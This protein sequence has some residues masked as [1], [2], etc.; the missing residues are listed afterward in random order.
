MKKHLTVAACLAA[1]IQVGAQQRAPQNESI[2]QDDMRAD[3][4]FLAGDSLRGRLTDTEENRASADFIRSRFERMGLKGAGPG[5]SFFQPYNLMT[6]TVGDPAANML[7]IAVADG[8]TRQLRLGQE[9]YPHRFSASGT[10]AGAVVFAGFGISAPHLG[11]D[12]YN[13][14]VKGKIVLALDHEPGERDPNSPFDGVVT[15]EPSAVWRKALAAQEKGAVAVLFVS[16]VHNHP[17]TASFEAAARNYWPGTPPRILNYTL[18]AWADRV[19]I[20]VAQISPAL[21]ASLV[22]GTSRSL[23]ELAKSAETAHGLPPLALPGTRI[24]LHTLVER[25]I[26]ADRNVV[27]LLE[28]SDPRLKN[29]WVIVSAHYDHNGADATQIF[30]GADDNGS[31]VV[32]LIEIAEAYALAAKEGHRPK[33]SILFASW[34]SEE[35]GLLGAWAYTEQPLAPLNTIAAVLNMDMIGRNEEIP[36]GG[37]ARFAGLEAQTAESNSNA[38]NLMA[39]SRVPDITTMVEKANNGIGLELKKRYDNNSSNL[40]R[41]SDQWPFLQRGVAAMGFITGLHPDYHTQYDR[42]EKINYVKMEKIARLVHQVSWDI[43]NAET[44][45]KAPASR[46]ITQH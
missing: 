2:R 23:E 39:F 6:S 12:D 22:S 7:E 9:F 20:P 45:P 1:V 14:D 43:A 37:G 42:P 40:L 31:G 5:G 4:F 46:S 17:G 36:I 26:V 41:R 16:D 8:V 10:V 28:G 32:A 11:Y 33:R 13:G 38:M 29:E 18:A 21:A 44:R 35:R 3:L 19:R 15:S 24:V 30:N 25:H 27:A 34:N